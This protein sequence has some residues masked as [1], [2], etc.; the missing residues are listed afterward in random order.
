MVTREA[1][2]IIVAQGKYLLCKSLLIF[3][4]SVL[5]CWE[6]MKPDFK[7]DQNREEW[8]KE[9]KTNMYRVRNEDQIEK[10][11]EVHNEIKKLEMEV[12][13]FISGD[14]W[15]QLYRMFLRS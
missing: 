12:G 15:I 5:F 11:L 9:V 7:L 14:I 1:R 13:T 4:V 3:F 6:A 10:E 2:K 8:L